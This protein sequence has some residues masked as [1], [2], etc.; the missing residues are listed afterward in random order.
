PGGSLVTVTLTSSLSAG[1][2]VLGA[3]LIGDGV[4]VVA[5]AL[6]TCLF[7]DDR[8]R[9]PPTPA[10]ASTAA[11][12][13]IIGVRLALRGRR[14]GGSVTS[15]AAPSSVVGRGAPPGEAGATIPGRTASIACI[16]GALAAAIG[17]EYAG[18]PCHDA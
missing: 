7:D 17:D 6:S 1:S 13:A 10:S 16:V 15:A 18:S 2:V 3:S 14:V 9:Y 4:V 5:V 11:P 8:P 12:I